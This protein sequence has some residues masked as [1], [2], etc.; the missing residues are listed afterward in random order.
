MSKSKLL[1]SL[2]ISRTL[3]RS[4]IDVL[5]EEAEELITNYWIE[6]KE[7]NHIERN[8]PRDSKTLKKEYLGSYAPKVELI[9]NARKV[10]ITWHQF[11]PYKNR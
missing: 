11:S 10:T 4:Q 3:L 7:R 9:G 6:W 8:L 2:E 5:R 1:K